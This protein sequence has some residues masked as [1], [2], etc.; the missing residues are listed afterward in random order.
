MDKRSYVPSSENASSVPKNSPD[1]TGAAN[2]TKAAT[3]AKA[4]SQGMA[5]V[6]ALLGKP[7]VESLGPAPAFHEQ[8]RGSHYWHVF[9]KSKK[10]SLLQEIAQHLDANYIIDLDPVDLL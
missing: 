9:V 5:L 4:Q 10:R 1:D 6:K 8:L 3:A 2:A 7:H